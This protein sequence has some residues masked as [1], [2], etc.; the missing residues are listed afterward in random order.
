M[1]STTSFSIESKINSKTGDPFGQ[2]YAGIFKVR[3]PS[4]G[5]KK[6]IALKDAAAM[7]VYGRVDADQVSEG[8]K[9]ISYI[10][11][12]VCHVALDKTPEWFDSAKLFD[13]SDELAML[14]VWE[15]VQTFLDSFRP[16]K[17]GGAGR[18]AVPGAAGVVSPQV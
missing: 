9:L 5:D 1:S 7:N 4:I 17:S 10:E 3:R 6:A 2:K 18:G 11:T 14:A 15:E 12:F 16:E 13:D 8:L